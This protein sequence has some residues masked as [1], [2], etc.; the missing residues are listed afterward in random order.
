MKWKKKVKGIAFRF[1]IE[2]KNTRRFEA[3]EGARDFKQR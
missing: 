3:Q 2:S 1:K